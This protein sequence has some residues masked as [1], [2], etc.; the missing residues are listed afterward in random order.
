MTLWFWRSEVFPF[1]SWPH[2]W[3][4]DISGPGIKSKPQ[5][6]PTPQLQQCWIL[7]LL[8]WVADWNCVATATQ[9]TSVKFLTYCITAG[10][11]IFTIFISSSWIDHYVVSAFVSYNSLSNVTLRLFS[12]PS[13]P[14]THALFFGGKACDIVTAD[15]CWFGV[16]SF[17]ISWDNNYHSF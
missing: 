5:L 8:C 3:H 9:A 4:M 17:G 1:L 15:S 13:T 6:Q 11:P 14:I 7:N 16:D 2:L 10:T 12:Y